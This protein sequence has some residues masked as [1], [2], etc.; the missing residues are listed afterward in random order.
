[1]RPVRDGSRR[2]APHNAS[3]FGSA[4]QLGDGPVGVR[5]PIP[6]FAEFSEPQR[7]R[8][9]SGPVAGK[10]CVWLRKLGRPR[11]ERFAPPASRCSPP[12]RSALGATSSRLRLQS[13]RGPDDCRCSAPASLQGS[14]GCASRLR[15]GPDRAGGDRRGARRRSAAPRKLAHKRP[16]IRARRRPRATGAPIRSSPVRPRAR[17]GRRGHA[18]SRRSSFPTE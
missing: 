6:G 2:I 8:R 15:T 9:F 18:G 5:P 14:R 12:R 3:G 16:P 1:M 10:L 11:N 17:R 13:A 4:R 7:R